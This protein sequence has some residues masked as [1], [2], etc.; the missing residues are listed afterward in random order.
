MTYCARYRFKILT[1]LKMADGESLN[2]NIPGFPPATLDVGQDAY[3]SGKWAIVRMMGFAT[4]EEALSFGQQLGDILSLVGAVTKLGI[5]VGFSRSTLRFSKA[6]EDAIPKTGTQLRT[7]I[8]GLMVYEENTVSIIGMDARGSALIAPD[9]L[10]QRLTEWV[11][12][13]KGL[14]ERQRNCAALLNDS[15]FVPQTEGQFVL[16]ISAVEALCD[17]SD[18]GPDYQAAIVEIEAFVAGQSL[19]PDVRKTITQ[20]LSFQKRQSLRQSYMT[21]FRALL[22]EDQAKAFDALYRKRST[23]VHDGR[24][25]GQL[26]EAANEALDLA[27]ALLAAELK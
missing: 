20:S 14:T 26:N 18:V 2:L 23:L 9:A 19:S 16:R 22:S 25:R 27:V 7:E 6:I 21:K 1:P 12:V 24:G 4:E 5:D 15:F 13:T 11:L 10:Q 17:Q 3:P 8:H